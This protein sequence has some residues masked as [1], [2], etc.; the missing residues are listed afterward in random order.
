MSYSSI[1]F[2]TDVLSHGKP[3]L[4]APPF[5]QHAMVAR[6]VIDAGAGVP[7]E[8]GWT[9]DDYEREIRRLIDEAGYTANAEK[10]AGEIARWPRGEVV[11]ERIVAE[12]EALLG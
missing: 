9:A 10:L 5:V 4:L 2:V 7:G 8:P 6:R 11:E 12:C 1:G 3:L